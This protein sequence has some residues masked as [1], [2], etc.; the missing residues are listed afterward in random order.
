MCK[1]AKFSIKVLKCDEKCLNFIN[2]VIFHHP[3]RFIGGEVAFC[4][5]NVSRIAETSKPRHRDKNKFDKN[6]PK[7]PFVASISCRVCSE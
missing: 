7:K 2:F 4:I 1:S 3:P 5:T 6:S